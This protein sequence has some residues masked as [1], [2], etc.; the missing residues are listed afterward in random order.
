MMFF[1]YLGDGVCWQRIWNIPA[2]FESL[3]AW[4]CEKGAEYVN[5]GILQFD[6]SVMVNNEHAGEYKPWDW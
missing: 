4:H 2:A 5:G 6:G 1:W 3:T